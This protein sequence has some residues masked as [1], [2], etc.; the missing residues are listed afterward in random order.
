MR[1]LSEHEISVVSG[2]FDLSGIP[3][4]TNVR[5]R[6]KDSLGDYTAAYGHV[7]GSMMWTARLAEL[8]AS[9]AKKA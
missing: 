2:G 8:A 7:V 9:M 1:E 5:D 4:S 3:P 6:G